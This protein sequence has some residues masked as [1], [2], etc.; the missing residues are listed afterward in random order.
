MSIDLTQLCVGEHATILESL[1][2]L[3]RT[4]LEIVFVVGADGRVL[5][6]LTDGDL[7]RALL[8]GVALDTPG[9]HRA[10]CRDFVSVGEGAS[11]AEVLD[12]MR[13]RRIS[14]VP[15][16][17]AARRL[18]GVHLVHELI[19]AA[20]RANSAVIMA[21]GRGTRLHPLTTD[22]PK[23]MLTVG[24]R[25]ILE[26]LVAHLVGFGVREIYLA[27]NYLAETI[28][29]HFG[30]GR[31]FGC[32]IHY[33]REDLP[34]GTGG[35]LSLLPQLPAEPLLV[36]N[37]DLV[38][39]F[40]VGRMLDTHRARGHVLTVGVRPYQVD[41]PFGVVD[42]D[43]GRVV[44]LR[45]KPTEQ[46]LVSGGIYVLAADLV[47]RVPPREPFP[48]TRLIEDCVNRRESV[49]AHL[50]DDEWI[51]VG[52]HDELRRARGVT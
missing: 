14:Q 36:M 35:A 22:V 27:V 3:D 34:L 8:A 7:R 23:P 50:I 5:G 45:E 43:D 40:D 15:V 9:A 25:P 49:G 28:E 52:R 26:R 19:G 47:A 6:T 42:V 48:I 46:M 13:H 31:L 2:V 39:Q 24:G 30:D 17:D 41:I 12:I 21:G 33:L 38:T 10:M 44:R 37:G 16:L 20:T 51:D 29:A 18:V 32:R 11:R 4:G 1:R